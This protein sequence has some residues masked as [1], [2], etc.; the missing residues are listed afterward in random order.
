MKTNMT[1]LITLEPIVVAK[2]NN[3]NNIVM[4]MMMIKI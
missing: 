2:N 1:T 4:T 3:A